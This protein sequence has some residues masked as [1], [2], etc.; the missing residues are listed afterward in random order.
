MID[1]LPG[2]QD[3]PEAGV[4]FLWDTDVMLLRQLVGKL[5]FLVYT[6]PISRHGVY[7]YDPSQSH[8]L[9]GG[10]RVAVQVRA[11]YSGYSEAGSPLSVVEI[12]FFR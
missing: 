2:A 7:R 1:E 3:E 12:V 4:G 11:M 10:K 8:E 9:N 6:Y 5:R